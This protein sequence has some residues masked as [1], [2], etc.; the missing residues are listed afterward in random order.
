VRKDRELGLFT[1]LLLIILTQIV[2][3]IIILKDE[4]LNQ[5]QHDNGGESSVTLNLFQGLMNTDASDF[6]CRT[7]AGIHQLELEP[8]KDYK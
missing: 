8:F 2:Q 5:V 3:R 4:M 7:M 6:D 1:D